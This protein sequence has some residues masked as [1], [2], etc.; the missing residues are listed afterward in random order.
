MLGSRFNGWLLSLIHICLPLEYALDFGLGLPE[1]DGVHPVDPLVR[2][3]R[4]DGG[5]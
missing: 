2:I 5:A 1:V 3:I 4:G